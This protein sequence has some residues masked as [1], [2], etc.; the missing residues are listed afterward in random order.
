MDSVQ[1]GHRSVHAAKHHSSTARRLCYLRDAVS[2]AH[3][4]GPQRVSFRWR[5]FALNG[6]ESLVGAGRNA[7]GAKRLRTAL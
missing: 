4:D 3:A 6:A 2:Y 5:L 7:A 1:A